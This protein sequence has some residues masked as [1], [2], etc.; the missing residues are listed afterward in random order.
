MRCITKPEALNIPPTPSRKCTGSWSSFPDIPG[1]HDPR[2][3]WSGRGEPLVEVNSGSQYGCVGL[4]LV[5]LRTVWPRLDDV[6][7]GN[8]GR[9]E[10][11]IELR[12]KTQK[13]DKAGTKGREFD[14]AAL[15]APTG[16]PHLTEITKNPRSSRSEVE[17]NWVLFFQRDG[18]AWVQYEMMGKIDG[19]EEII[20]QNAGERSGVRLDTTKPSPSA[21]RG[22]TPIEK[23]PAPTETALTTSEKSVDIV[24]ELT[25]GTAP[26]LDVVE[27]ET[28]LAIATLEHD[29]GLATLLEPE[30]K[31]LI[32]ENGPAK[33]D[34]PGPMISIA[35]LASEPA[36]TLT[37][38]YNNV[39]KPQEKDRLGTADQSAQK[40]ETPETTSTRSF[41]FSS[42]V[43]GVQKDAITP[44]ISG[45][46][47]IAQL[48][49]H[50]YT[51]TNLTSPQEPPCF[52]LFDR[53]L[54]HDPLGNIGHWHQ[55]S[56]SLRLVLCTREQLHQRTCI[57][58]SSTSADVPPEH[59]VMTTA[60]Y[61]QL[62]IEE[63]LIV[64]FSIVHRKFNNEWGLPMRYERYFLLWEARR[65]FRT[66]AV[67]RYPVLFGG[68][69]ARPWIWEE[70]LGWDRAHELENRE[71]AHEVGNK[72]NADEA[73]KGDEASDSVYFTYTPSIAWA[74]RA[75][76]EDVLGD[77]DR[78]HHVLGTG[79]LDEEIVIGI[80]MDDV[81]QHFVQMKVGD[82]L[83]CL[84]FCP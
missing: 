78:R 45:G 26:L 14:L 51:T 82:V 1:F 73:A 65:P 10:Q 43:S 53:V 58:A 47:T 20:S 57:P 27:T 61:E 40:K 13:A 33:R 54:T 46:R 84:S 28:P 21:G 62:L 48:L 12:D 37:S 66:V 3:F 64:H 11:N 31:N 81:G 4:W 35:S 49:S 7:Q 71:K 80:G 8:K 76:S 17:K 59:K 74:W 52:N 5:D 68:E 44:I 55:G 77:T 25:E 42:R 83:G 30:L 29:K 18:E 63:G 19:H 41:E 56:N 23:S 9:A 75:K 22:G 39:G 16:Y 67:S 79:F 32:F 70:D 38:D 34:E 2:I 72:D 50:G 24:L 69:R 60:Q 15:G 6:M 36:P